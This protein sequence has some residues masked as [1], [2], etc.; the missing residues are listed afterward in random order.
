MAVQR[1][2]KPPYAKIH[3]IHY[4]PKSQCEF[5]EVVEAEGYYMARCR[6]LDRFIVRDL[7]YK[8]EKYWDQ[9]PYRRNA[10]RLESE[11]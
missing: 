9:C 7:V 10:L 11:Q 4:K 1:Q 5:F 8:C 3:A 2:K 6:A